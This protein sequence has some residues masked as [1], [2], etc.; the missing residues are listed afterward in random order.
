MKKLKFNFYWIT[1]PF[2]FSYFI[3]VLKTPGHV[4]WNASPAWEELRIIIILF[5]T[6]TIYR[7][8]WE[9]DSIKCWSPY[10]FLLGVFAG[11]GIVIIYLML[12]NIYQSSMDHLFGS[13]AAYSMISGIWASSEKR[14]SHAVLAGFSCFIYQLIIDFIAHTWWGYVA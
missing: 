12:Q 10:S 5:W 9:N 3:F 2:I 7:F 1:V 13:L 4:Y 11:G 14:K 6:Y 8:R